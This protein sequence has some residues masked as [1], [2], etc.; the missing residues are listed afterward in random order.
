MNNAAMDICLQDVVCLHFSR[1]Y[2][3]ECFA[4]S[5]GTF[6]FNDLRNFQ[7]AFQS[8]ILGYTSKR[9]ILSLFNFCGISKVYLNLLECFHRKAGGG[10]PIVA[11]W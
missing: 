4:G 7:A 10:V 5:C 3:L 6:V 9:N 11:Q 8:P 2:T 1:V